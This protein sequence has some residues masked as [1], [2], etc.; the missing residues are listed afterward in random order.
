VE[1]R[2]PSRAPST[3]GFH[4]LNGG[5]NRVPYYRAADDILLSVQNTVPRLPGTLVVKEGTAAGAQ[6][7]FF[8]EWQ[9][10]VDNGIICACGS[11]PRICT[12]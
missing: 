4:G 12:I 10:A 3:A 11:A 7:H 5:R 8:E 2:E 9:K 6:G 1:N